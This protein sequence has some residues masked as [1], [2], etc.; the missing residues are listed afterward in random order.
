MPAESLG[1]SNTALGRKVFTVEQANRALPLVRRVVEDIVYAFRELHSL[2]DQIADSLDRGTVER[3][4]EAEAQRLEHLQ[5]ELEGVG[6]ELKDPAVGLI[7]FLGQY[8]GREIYLC[9]KLGEEHVEHWHELHSGF[10]ARR[11]VA[12]LDEE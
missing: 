5:S 1:G 7:D 6:C 11:P 3:E 12:Q 2:R 9:W 4:I 10:A 8:Q